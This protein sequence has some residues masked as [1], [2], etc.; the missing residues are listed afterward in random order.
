MGGLLTGYPKQTQEPV[1]DRGWVGRWLG[2]VIDVFRR[3]RAAVTMGKSGHKGLASGDRADRTPR[4]TA[5]SRPTNFPGHPAP[6]LS[7]CPGRTRNSQC[8]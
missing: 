7:G 6:M 3:F 2:R 5:T 8:P 4:A 1:Q